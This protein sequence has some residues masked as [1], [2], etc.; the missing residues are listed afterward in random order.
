MSQKTL[1]LDPDHPPRT[2]T[3]ELER[4][5]FFDVNERTNGPRTDALALMFANL[6]SELIDYGAL[7]PDSVGRILAMSVLDIEIPEQQPPFPPEL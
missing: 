4:A 2:N 1:I 3:L 5:V 7:L 6:L